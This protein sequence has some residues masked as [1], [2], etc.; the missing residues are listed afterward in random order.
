VIRAG[1]L[2]GVHK[3]YIMYQLLNSLAFLHSG[4]LLHRD[5]K[6]SN[7]L[8]NAE[9]QVKLADFGLARSVAALEAEEAAAAAA[10]GGFGGF[11]GGPVLT[12]YVAT[13]W[14]RA[15]EILL[16]STRYTYAVDMWSAGCILAELLAGRP[17][18]P[19]SSTLNQLDRILAL[20]GRPSEAELASCGS[21]YAS[22]LLDS[23]P[24][25]LAPPLPLAQRYPGAPPE[26]LDLLARVLRFSPADRLTAEQA[27]RHPYVA[28]FRGGGSGLAEP[29]C[30]APVSIPI[31]DNLRC[32]VG[33]YRERLYAEVVRRKKELRRRQRQRD[34]AA[35]AEA[36]AAAAA[37]CTRGGP[38]AP[39]AAAASAP[40][41]SDGRTS[42]GWAEAAAAVRSG[43]EAA[44]VVT[45]AATPLQML[46][47]PAED[48]PPPAPLTAQGR[49]KPPRSSGG[50][51]GGCLGMGSS[52]FSPSARR[53]SNSGGYRSSR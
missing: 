29:R 12:D 28:A 49:Q 8:V 14:Y 13:R 41:P 23:L 46:A 44:A 32:G 42:N 22:M 26:A 20:T 15:P 7:L 18:F 51:G 2:E 52:A 39:V 17:A 1:I 11:A 33:E 36:G 37:A 31:D 21:P 35:A 3:Q 53:N 30:T 19:G 4:E 40:A 24:P 43:R 6:P 10:A 25:A 45:S 27:L 47:A 5:V 48:A 34:A 38:A 9:C 16:G 50:G